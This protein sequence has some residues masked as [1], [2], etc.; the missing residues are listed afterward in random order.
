LDASAKP[1]SLPSYPVSPKEKEAIDKALQ[2]DELRQLD[3]T[4]PSTSPWE[5]P[6]LIVNKK[7]G[8]PRPVVD[9]RK[10]LNEVVN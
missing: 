5:A 2:L 3:I 4:E 9:F 10:T 8:S 7:D 6:V 1:K